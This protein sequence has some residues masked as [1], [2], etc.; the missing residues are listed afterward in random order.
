M[1]RTIN[2]TAAPG[3]L[4]ADAPLTDGFHLLLDALKLNDVDTI[5]GVVGI[6]ITDLARLAQ[7]SAIRYIGFRHEYSAGSAAAAAGFLTKKPG[8]LLTVSGPGFL[9]GLM[10]VANATVNCFPV[11][12][13]AGSSARPVVDLER[14]DYEELDQLAVA[15]PLVK[16]AYRV[17]RAQDIGRGVA[18]AIRTAV[19]GRPGGVYLDVPA[20]VL[21][22]AVD[23]IDGAKS[24]WR[25]TDPAPRQFPAP[26][27]VDRAFGLL[28]NARQPLIVLGKGAAYAQADADI[29]AF[30][31]TTGIPF[32]PMPMAKGL[33]PDDH[34]QSVAAA[35]SLALS[36]ADV[37]LL[38]GARLN[39]LLGHGESPHWAPDALFIQA[40][41]D[42]SEMDSNQPIEAPLV[43]DIGAVM[44]ALNNRAQSG[45][46]TAPT[47]WRDELAAR[48]TRNIASM[49]SRLA[50]DPSPMRFYN[51]LCA[52]REVLADRP[53]VYVVNEGANTLDITRNVIDMKL[54]RH[55]LDCG[56][57]G[58]MGIGM[59]YAIAAAVETGAPVVA[60][61]GDSAFGFSGMEIETICRYQ[62]PI[63]VV[64]M[65]N[66]G[67]YRG[68]DVNGASADPAPTVLDPAAHHERLIEAFGGTGYHVTTPAQLSAA[69]QKALA[70]GKP[71]LVDVVLDPSAGTESGHIGNLN[72]KS[73]A[74]STP[75]QRTGSGRT[76][77]PTV[78]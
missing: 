55:R 64:I 5:Y 51:A 52:V 29:R 61:E 72:P 62:L 59:G 32:L 36:E 50:A 15:R 25:V 58:V 77:T 40:D 66:G 34:P 4:A 6:P 31:E 71:A 75:A 53:D 44:E 54:P 9:N 2:E 16:A 28:A 68:D 22:E 76:S 19:S 14:G 13:I 65:N 60:I 48:K 45:R 3:A 10:A 8:I 21:G 37:V 63:T 42:A 56:T 7:M 73:A 70:S 57:W 27:A 23:A 39:W 78:A 49:R 33:L 20:A 24:L 17:D 26:E 41:I 30:V 12:H 11:V 74:P 46:I 67:V 35:R 1:S 43:G 47:A 18:R 38:V 69:L